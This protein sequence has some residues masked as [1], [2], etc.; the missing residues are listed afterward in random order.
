MPSHWGAHMTFVIADVLFPAFYSPYFAHLMYPLSAL[1]ALSAECLVFGL[2][3]RQHPRSLLFLIVI[4]ANVASSLA[5]I[6]IAA[7]L[8][9]GLHLGLT[10]SLDPIDG[11]RWTA[12]VVAAWLVAFGASIVLE[13]VVVRAMTRRVPLQYPGLAVLAANVASYFVLLVLLQASVWWSLHQ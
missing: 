10:R 11:G 7:L 12:L 2:L 4:V 8:S 5:G 6:A 1:V 13:Y 3:N 9:E